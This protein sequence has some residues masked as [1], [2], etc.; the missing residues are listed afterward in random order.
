VAAAFSVFPIALWFVGFGATAPQ[1]GDATNVALYAY[2]GYW[3]SDAGPVA[4]C[5]SRAQ[6]K[7]P[8]R[9][10]YSCRAG[11]CEHRKPRPS[12]AQPV[13]VM[14]VKVNQYP[15]LRRWTYNGSPAGRGGRH[16]SVNPH[17]VNPI[18]CT[19]VGY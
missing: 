9:V 17:E 1:L 3:E 2:T 18:D 6:I 4:A 7:L 19:A 15:L 12:Q 5:D 13:Y 11:S 8:L 16:G 10:T 14:R